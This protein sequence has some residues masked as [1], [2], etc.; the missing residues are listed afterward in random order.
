MTTFSAVDLTNMRAT[1]D[2]HMMGTCKFQAVVETV[3]AM[4]ELVQ[5]WPADGAEVVCGLDMR[6]GIERHLTDKTLLEYDATIRLPIA[7]APDAKDRIKVTKRFG[8]ALGAA[9]IYE[10]VGP[11]QRG[12]SGIR[13][14]LKRV[15]T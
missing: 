2:A 14:L 1:Q 5:T 15:E 13:L 7:S 11:I 12:P 6:S 9:L 10:I 8:E 3:D 4:R